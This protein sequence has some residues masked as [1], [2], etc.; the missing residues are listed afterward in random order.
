[1]YKLIFFM[2]YHILTI[3]YI[4]FP[5]YY[6]FLQWSHA[7]RNSFKEIIVRNPGHH[8]SSV[9]SESNFENRLQCS[10]SPGTD[11]SVHY[12]SGGY[13]KK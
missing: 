3:C 6:L 5:F 12:D 7:Q 10:A 13:G 9:I 4:F 2:I 8:S 1:M 11:G